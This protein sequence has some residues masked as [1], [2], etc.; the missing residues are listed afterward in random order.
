MA[1]KR[2]VVA[3]NVADNMNA[4]DSKLASMFEKAADTSAAESHDNAADDSPMHE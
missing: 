1:K 2:P 3:E 4:A